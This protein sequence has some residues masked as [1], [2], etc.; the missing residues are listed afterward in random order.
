MAKCP[1]CN[2]SV[3]KKNVKARLNSLRLARPPKILNAID[4][5]FDKLSKHWTIDDTIKAGF[6]ADIEQVEGTIIID[7]IQKFINKGG[8][9]QGYNIKYLAGIIKNEGKRVLLRREWER[10]NL[11]RI[12]PKLKDSNEKSRIN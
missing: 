1:L 9:E 8:I 2:G 6:L 12:P 3:S 11:D 10:K 7:S 4:K 5:V